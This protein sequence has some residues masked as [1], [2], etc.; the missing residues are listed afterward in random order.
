MEAIF[1]ENPSYRVL[2]RSKLKALLKGKV[3]PGEIDR[4]VNSSELH[5][6]HT[7]ALP[8]TKEF[9][10]ITAVPNCFQI[11]VVI[12]KYKSANSGKDRFLLI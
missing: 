12:Y 5:Q 4:Y 3:S 2:G 7:C 11:D 8:K 6:T 1:K 10:R 9:R